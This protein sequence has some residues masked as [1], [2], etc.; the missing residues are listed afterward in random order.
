MS[1]TL[2]VPGSAALSVLKFRV[3]DA[4]MAVR[5]GAV[6]EVTRAPLITRVPHAPPCVLGVS[7]LR[8]RVT[9]V[10]SAARLLQV[11]ERPASASNRTIILD[12]D[13]PLALVVD[14][15][16]G[17]SHIE[18]VSDGLGSLFVENDTA[19]RAIDLKGVLDRAFGAGIIRTGGGE[20]T[21]G[22]QV[23]ATP[24]QAAPDT[25]RLILT[26]AVGNQV[27]ALE[28]GVVE[29]VMDVPDAIAA[30]PQGAQADLGVIP[31]R[32]GVLPVVDLAVLLGVQS[33]GGRG[34]LVVIRM[35]E[36]LAG[37]RVDRL[38]VIRRVG[39]ADV[40]AAPALLNRGGGEAAVEAIVR[41]DRSRVVLL[42]TPERLFRAD[43]LEKIMSDGR[44]ELQIAAVD[45]DDETESFL[46]FQLGAETYAL[47]I[48]DVQE[49]IAVPD[50]LTRVPNAPAFIEG[51]ISL[52]GQVVPVIDQASRFGAVTEAKASRKIIVTRSDTLQAGFIIDGVSAIRAIP[53]RDL[54]TPSDLLSGERRLFDRVARSTTGDVILIVDPRA[55]LDQAEADVLTALSL[56]AGTAS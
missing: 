9:P 54:A 17:L 42:L 26:F 49:V 51:V 56:E 45:V 11:D 24:L 18:A 28:L 12:L 21:A 16:I 33:A 52:R 8:G 22:L 23:P 53:Q 46:V 5:S 29:E 34:R 50:V 40:T 39:E 2:A 38:E 55:L 15:V 19:V 14:E 48:D 32:S 10:V 20:K 31:Y 27:H 3:A 1:E 30:L 43:A 6:E 7:N 37:L 4:I 36:A 35:G 41:V 44:R 25:T 47:P 13:P